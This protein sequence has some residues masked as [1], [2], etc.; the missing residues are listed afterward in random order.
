M[1]LVFPNSVIFHRANRLS[2]SMRLFSVE[3][4]LWIYSG[5]WVTEH[6]WLCIRSSKP[7]P[8]RLTC[9]R[10]SVYVIPKSGRQARMSLNCEKS[11]WRIDDVLWLNVYVHGALRKTVPYH[12]CVYMTVC[13]WLFS[14]AGAGW[15]TQASKFALT[16]SEIDSRNANRK[17]RKGW[18]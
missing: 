7:A 5:W 13:L 3:C 1:T 14:E 12:N 17:G 10:T 11:I 8:D 2:R 9:L 6:L 15:E 4:L 18:A 16:E